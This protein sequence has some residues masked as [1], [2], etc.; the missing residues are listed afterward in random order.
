MPPPRKSSGEQPAEVDQ[1]VGRRRLGAAA[2][3]GGRARHGA[4]RARPDAIDAARI[5]VRD[6]A[7]AGADRVDVD[8]R[9]H[10]LVRADLRVEQVLHPQPAVLR[11]A[12]VRRGAADV[13]RDHVVVA[14]LLARPD[15]ADDAG[16]RAGHQQVDRARDRAPQR[17]RRRDADV[18]RWRP[19][20][21]PE[22]GSARPAA[23]RR[24]TRHLRPDVRVQADRGEALVLAVLRARPRTRQRGTPRG[25]PRARSRPRAAR[26]RGSGTRRGSRPRPR[27]PAPPSAPGPAA[28]ASSSSSGTSTEPSPMMRSATVS[29]WR[30]RTTG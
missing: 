19:V 7:A 26:A 24:T 12:D 18:I 13:E 25:T 14:R 20:P 30:R 8:H 6:R 29:R 1:R 2:A 9:D 28:R 5:D 16:D 27:R 4:G 22:R 10:R 3:V 17:W 15:A 23:W 11:E 21:H